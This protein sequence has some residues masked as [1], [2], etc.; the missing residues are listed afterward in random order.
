MK[1]IEPKVELLSEISIS[2]ESHIARCAR[3]CYIEGTEILTNNGFKLFK[4]I[5]NN[6]DL[7]LTYNQKINKLEWNKPNAFSENYDGDII[8][9]NHKQ[10][11]FA[12]TPNHRVV[13]SSPY[14]REF[15][16]KTAEEVYTELT[17]SS[18]KTISFRFPKF[19]RDAFLDNADYTGEIK[20]KVEINAGSGKV[21]YEEISLPINSDFIDL[22][23]AF[24]SEGHSCDNTGKGC[25]SYCQITQDENHELY[26]ITI[27]ALKNL[28]IRYSVCSDPRKRNIKWIR[29]GNYAF[30]KTFKN[31]FGKGSH[32]I[33]LPEWFRNLSYKQ[34]ERLLYVLLLGDGSHNTKEEQHYITASKKLAEQIQELYIQLGSNS[35]Y[36]HHSGSNDCL[37]VYK[38]LRDSWVIRPINVSKSHYRGKVYCTQ[39]DNGIVCVRYKGCISWCGNCYGKEYKEPNQEADKKMVEGLIKREHLS[40]LR[41]ASVYISHLEKILPYLEEHIA[42]SPYWNYNMSHK[43]ASTNLQEFMQSKEAREPATVI[44]NSKFLE[45]CVKHSELF[46]LYR[47][48]FCITTQIS[49]SRELNRV[50]PNAIAERSTR[51]CS[52]KDGLEICRPWWSKSSEEDIINGRCTHKEFLYYINAISEAERVYK[53]LLDEGMKPEDT[54]GLLPLDTATKVIYT[55]SIREW[56]HILDLRYYGTTGKPHPNAKLIAGKIRDEINKFAIEHG[57]NYKV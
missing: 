54:R 29:F 33:H 21:G 1:I 2:P 50:S 37:N 36:S 40:M 10:I 7:V 31:L 24:I 34:K 20:D 52:S 43:Y 23:G 26:Q 51:Y 4:E 27:N 56:Q 38:S 35:Y 41:H 42:N 28:G 6:K 8:N 17:T 16:F 49:T 9:F 12:V 11:K 45:E 48:T 25:G 13:C 5:D 47:L 53:S 18:K 46:E 15:K 19:F 32:N 22:M 30:V 39:T 55:Y 3:V 44:D 57:I 14:K